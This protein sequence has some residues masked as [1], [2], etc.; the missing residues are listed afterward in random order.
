MS[1]VQRLLPNR[2]SFSGDHIHSYCVPLQHRRWIDDDDDQGYLL[3]IISE[4]NIPHTM[5]DTSTTTAI[6]PPITTVS[7]FFSEI[8]RMSNEDDHDLLQEARLQPS[9]FDSKAPDFYSP[10]PLTHHVD[11]HSKTERRKEEL[12][13]LKTKHLAKS[14][15]R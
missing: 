13:A 3:Q 7:P 6:G 1:Q 9:I 11:Y 10:P 5:T 8:R 12:E 15:G 4:T 14:K 2:H